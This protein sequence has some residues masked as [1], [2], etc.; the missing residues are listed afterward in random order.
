MKALVSLTYLAALVA[1]VLLPFDLVAALSLLAVAA[2]LAIAISDY[3]RVTRRRFLRIE[4]TLSRKER[5]GL[6]A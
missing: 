2:L 4:A 3:T 6:A 1:F 5:L